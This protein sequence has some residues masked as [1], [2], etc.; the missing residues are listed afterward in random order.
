MSSLEACIPDP[1]VVSPDETVD[2]ALRRIEARNVRTAPV[3][4]GSGRIV[5]LFGLHCL[6][7]HLLPL[8]ARM[9]DGLEDLDFIVDGAPLAA[10]R[11]RQIGLSPVREHMDT[12]MAGRLLHPD[13]EILEVIRTLARHGSPLPVVERETGRFVGLV[14]EQSCLR[15]LHVVLR[16]IELEEARTGQA[17]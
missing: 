11:L 3:V 5:G 14:S 10:K 8:A 13:T 1:L 9:E 6:M 12:D 4:D 15:R 16:D 17:S 2:T 7:A